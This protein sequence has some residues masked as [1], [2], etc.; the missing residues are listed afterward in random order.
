MPHVVTLYL[1]HHIPT[2]EMI[3]EAGLT[4]DRE[5]ATLALANDP[6]IPD[7]DTARAIADDVF[8]ELKDWLPQF[9]GR[10]SF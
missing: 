10:W 4:G 7:P 1:M 9:N 2:Q 5:L 3:V 6:L 8:D